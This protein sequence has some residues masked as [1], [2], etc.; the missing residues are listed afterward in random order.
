MT[1]QSFILGL[2]FFPSHILP[3]RVST[4]IDTELVNHVPG[5]YLMAEGVGFE[6]TEPLGSPVFKTG[7]FVR[8]AIP[9][10]F[11]HNLF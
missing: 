4:L 8:S 3:L 2:A 7:A 5:I 10:E 11:L 9:P 6:P 1:F